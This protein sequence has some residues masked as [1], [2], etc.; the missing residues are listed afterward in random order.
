V[1]DDV[2]TATDPERLTRILELLDEAADRYQVLIL[3]CH[4]DGIGS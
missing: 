3:T 1:L 2:L 4:P